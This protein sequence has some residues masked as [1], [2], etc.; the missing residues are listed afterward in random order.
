MKLPISDNRKLK[1]L[2]SREKKNSVEMT[3]KSEIKL[4]NLPTIENGK[5]LIKKN[6]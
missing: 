6:F 4:I 5:V 2:R 1:F 3:K